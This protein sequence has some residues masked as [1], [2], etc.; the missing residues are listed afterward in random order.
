MS[1]S[2][3]EHLSVGCLPVPNRELTFK[4]VVNKKAFVCLGLLIRTTNK[5]L[6][7]VFK[8]AFELS[9]FLYACLNTI[10]LCVKLEVVES[11]KM[12]QSNH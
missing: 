1:C 10:A 7:K 6:L 11:F 3:S 2:L 9:K 4:G 5:I 12:S 8:A